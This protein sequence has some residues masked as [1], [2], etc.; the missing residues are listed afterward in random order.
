MTSVRGSQRVTSQN[1]E[2]TYQ[3]LERYGRDL[4]ELARKGKLDPVIGRD[5][6]IRR[7]I[8]V[9]SRRT[10]NNP[11]LIG[12]PG[13]GKTAVVEGLAQRIVRQDVPEGLKNKKIVALDMGALVAGA[14]YRGEFEE[15]LKAVLKEVA[16]AAGQVILFIDELHTVV[17]AGAAEGAM[18]ASNMLKP[19]LARGELHTVGATTLDEYRKHIEKD[20]A[21]ER[22]FQPVVVSEPSVEDTIS[23][24]RGLRE[25]YEVHH[26][27]KFKDSA[28][29]AA[30]V[31]SNRYITDR[32]LPDKA[33]DLIDEAA[34]RLRMEIDSMPAELDEVERRIMQL[35]IERE[36]LKKETDKPSK[37]RLQKL[38][39]EL[40]DLKEDKSQL[41]SHWQQEKETILAGRKLK[42]E[43]EQVRIEIDRAQRGGDYAQASELQYGAP[44]GAR[45][46]DQG[47]RGA[48]HHAPA[49]AA[50]VEG[51]SRRGGH[52]RRREPLDAH[53]GEPPDGG[54][55]PEAPPD[56][57]PAPRP[58]RRT[59]GSHLGRRQRD[60]TRAGRAAG[61]QPPPRQLH[62]PRPDRRRQDRA[63][64]CPRRVPVR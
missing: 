48:A 21:L 39:K 1:P 49:G 45:A 60:S 2:S 34:S 15:R 56:G 41:T 20:A 38:E 37:E 8:Q 9:L 52:R 33:I 29:V 6:E 42:E 50:D 53:P 10:K 35:E 32:F 51:R 43:L 26:G 61:P 25:R 47:R 58:R 46:A 63:G 62:L 22:R 11:V 30:A 54:R 23:I 64:A 40:A 44:A 24:L 4:T 19:M 28:L 5:D 17:G 7:V 36:A 18:D 3:A 57:S 27:V 13:V 59:G 55:D 12:E 31:L 14:K 16:D